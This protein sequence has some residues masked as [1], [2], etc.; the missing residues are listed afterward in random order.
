MEALIRSLKL[1]PKF[2]KEYTYVDDVDFLI[3][4]RYIR[5][6]YTDNLKKIYN[7][8]FLVS[9]DPHTNVLLCKNRMALFTI[10]FEDALVFQKKSLDERIVERA[11]QLAS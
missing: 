11:R 2:I 9:V 1:P 4:G 10:S 5:W 7:G 6:V 8:G 3:L